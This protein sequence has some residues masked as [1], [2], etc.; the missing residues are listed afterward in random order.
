M[1]GLIHVDP[2]HALTVS[3]EEPVILGWL[4]LQGKWANIL[5]DG[6]HRVY[7][8]A[9]RKKKRLLTYVLT[10]EENYRIVMGPLK[11]S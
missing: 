6:D 1:G 3:F 2:A 7:E 5:I 9:R 11:K 8:A 4:Y 10:P